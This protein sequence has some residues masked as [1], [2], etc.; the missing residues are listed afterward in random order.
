VFGAIALVFLGMSAEGIA[1]PFIQTP[2]EEITQGIAQSPQPV[3]VS[4]PGVRAHGERGSEESL[5]FVLENILH[6]PIPPI[7]VLTPSGWTTVTTCH[8]FF[9]TRAGDRIAIDRG[10]TEWYHYS[11]CDESAA[12]AMLAT[13]RRVEL[14]P[15]T[16][17]LEIAQT[18]P[19]RAL[20]LPRVAETWIKRYGPN[21]TALTLWPHANHFKM[22][23]RYS[24]RRAEPSQ[25]L[26][27]FR[28]GMIYITIDGFGDFDGD[29]VDDVLVSVSVTEDKPR[30]AFCDSQFL[31]RLTRR[32]DDGALV[33]H[34]IAHYVNVCPFG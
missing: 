17:M 26:L 11:G 8:E 13:P 1:Q 21:A 23:W 25:I 16:I 10:R 12:F 4:R 29:G 18:I 30:D 31:S 5:R 32:P 2:L 15:E 3:Y 22:R 20:G 28:Q 9:V 33:I 24:H 6:K 27:I 14:D 7:R 34:P 19:V